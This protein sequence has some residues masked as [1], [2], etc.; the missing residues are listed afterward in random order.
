MLLLAS[1]EKVFYTLS[2]S[3]LL[4]NLRKFS[5]AMQLNQWDYPGVTI[6]NTEFMITS[7][8]KN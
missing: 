6:D 8:G 2:N 3:A 5:C 1:W 4:Y 7:V